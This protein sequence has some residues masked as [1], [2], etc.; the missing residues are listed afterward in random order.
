MP[1]AKNIFILGGTALARQLA[2]TL[3]SHGHIV[4]TA[5]AGR[6]KNPQ[7][8]HGDLQIGPLGGI[9]GLGKNL[10]T[11]AIDLLIDATHPF[12]SQI[13][14]NA[15]AAAQATSIR[16]TRLQ[17]APWTSNT[18]WINCASYE[19]AAKALPNHA[20][21]LLTIGRQNIHHFHTRTDC[22][23]LARMIEPPEIKLPKN[24][25]P[26]F[27]RPPFSIE[28]EKELMRTNTITHLVTKNAGG[29]ATRAK[30]D[31]AKN[32]SIPTLMIARPDLPTCETF[33]NVDDLI[34]ALIL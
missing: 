2:D 11:R 21:A 4:T 10:S 34:D 9:A 18:N 24:F 15:F 8:P 27:A 28:A 30:I 3:V 19:E 13:S 22:T 16:L 31:A 6:T 12:A 29:T 5:L 14:H 17:T 25:N 26:H 7:V 23:F 32:L 20:C 1:A 33:N